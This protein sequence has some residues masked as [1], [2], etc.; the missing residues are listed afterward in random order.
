MKQTSEL[1]LQKIYGCVQDEIDSMETYILD[2]KKSSPNSL[3]PYLE[4]LFTRKGKRIRSCFVSL[5]IKVFSPKFNVRAGKIIT[6]IE[7]LHLATLVHDDIID[8]S[9]F[10]RNSLTAYRKWGAQKAVLV[11]DYIFFQALQIVMDD[12]SR[13]IPAIISECSSKLIS[14]EILEIEK[15]GDLSLSKEEYFE[16]I[17]GKTASLWEGAGEAAAIIANQPPNRIKECQKLGYLLGMAFQIIDDI[18]DYGVGA[19]NLDKKMNTDLNRS[20]MTL[21]LILFFNEAP[22]EQSKEMKGLLETIEE[23]PENAKKIYHLIE[24]LNGFMNAKKQAEAFIQ[25]ALDILDSFEMTKYQQTLKE[26][27]LLIQSRSY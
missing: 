21:P 13:R 19:E 5:I 8:E 14:G 22:T 15:I 2:L 17:Y 26:L 20:L 6:S 1:F 10:R 24:S 27:F 12:E 7:F 25:E 18:L 9:E 4:E 23:N 16:I 3:K 11:G